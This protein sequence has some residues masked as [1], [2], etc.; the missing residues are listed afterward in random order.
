MRSSTE[1]YL[2]N[3][4]SSAGSRDRSSRRKY[5]DTN[6]SSPLKPSAPAALAPRPASTAPRGTGRQASPPSARSARESSLASSSTPAASSSSSASCSSSRRSCTPI[7]C[8]DPCARQRASGSAGSSL[9]AIAICE[10]AGTYW[11][12]SASTSR[13]DGLATAC[14]SSSASTSGCSSA[15]SA[16]PTR[17]MRMAQVDPPGPGQ[18]VEHL[19]R[20]RLDPVNRGRDVAQEHHGRRRPARRARPTRTDADRPRP[21]ARAGSSCRSRRARR[22]SRKARSPSQSRAIRSAFATVP[23]RLN[24][25]ASLASARSKGTSVAAATGQCYDSHEETLVRTF[26]LRAVDFIRLV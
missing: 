2:R 13:Q 20:E 8:T 19:G 5:S 12:S 16:L 25:G 6:R 26:L 22:R 1:V 4:A 14:R 15:A 7:S 3:F 10:P 21:S 11:N 23:G 9:L 17:G 24:G 18:R